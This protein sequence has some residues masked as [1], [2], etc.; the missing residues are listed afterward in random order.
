[1][2]RLAWA[3]L[4]AATTLLAGCGR[5]MSDLEDYAREVKARTS[6]QIEPIPQIKNF[7]P[8]V[9]EAGERRDPFLPLLASRDAAAAAAGSG[10]NG[11]KPDTDRP[12]EPLEEFPIDALR[13]VGTITMQ[14][15]GYA[16]IKAPDA[17][18]HRVSVGDHLGQNYGKITGISET[19]VTV[20]EIILD[21]F[22][23]WMQRPATIALVQ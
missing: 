2:S 17:V 8:Y 15:R 3:M 9:Y 11:L 23:G 7:E 16:L 4:A 5:D 18:V 10:G 6:R 13:M 21:G 20:M 14:Q 22:G 19:E 12:K 1:M